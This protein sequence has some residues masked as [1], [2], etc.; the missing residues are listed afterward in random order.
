MTV[1]PRLS[2]AKS[3]DQVEP[4]LLPGHDITDEVLTLLGRL[5]T[6]RVNTEQMLKNERERVK[7]LGNSIDQLACRRMQELPNAV[8]RGIKLLLSL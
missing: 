4:E 5:E 3:E 8:Q 1:T 2:S 7:Q 6:D